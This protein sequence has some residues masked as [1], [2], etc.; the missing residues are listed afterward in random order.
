[1]TATP[2]LRVRVAATPVR[3]ARP[4]RPLRAKATEIVPGAGELLGFQRKLR[5]S[6]AQTF[7]DDCQHIGTD[8]WKQD[9]ALAAVRAERYRDASTLAEVLGTGRKYHGIAELV[10]V[11][12]KLPADRIRDAIYFKGSIPAHG[13]PEMPAWGNVFYLLKSR[14]KVLEERVRDLTAY[15]ESIQTKR[16]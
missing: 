15:I 9:V 10:A 14:P 12:G 6:A 5:E 11:A 7:F 13:T 1:V 2:A 16:K 8:D 4:H 3:P